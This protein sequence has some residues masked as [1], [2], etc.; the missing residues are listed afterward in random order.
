MSRERD[1]REVGGARAECAWGTG[2]D[3]LV[4]VDRA[5]TSGF[6]FLS[7]GPDEK[8]SATT[9]G[10]LGLTL[11]EALALAAQLA[12]AAVDATRLDAGYV[13]AGRQGASAPKAPQ[14]CKRCTGSIDREK[15]QAEI[16]RVDVPETAK[17]AA[18][19]SVFCS[20]RCAF[21]DFASAPPSEA[22]R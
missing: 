20:L 1:S 8:E 15:L 10:S 9:A 13:E 4:V 5:N 12:Q 11:P 21:E 19:N 16:A 22:G 2:P 7:H 18:R 14:V 6:P 3:V 17:R